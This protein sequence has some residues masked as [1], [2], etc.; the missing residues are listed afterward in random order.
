MMQ[1]LVNGVHGVAVATGLW[2]I[3]VPGAVLWGALSALLRFLP[4]F[5]PWIAAALPITLSIA[6][7]H[8]WNQ[9]LL[10]VGMF[11]VLELVSNNVLEPWLYGAS[12]GLSPFG[13]IVSAV[14]WTWLWGIPGLVIATPLTVCFVV[15]GRYVHGLRHFAVLLGDQPALPPDVRLYQRLLAQDLDEAAVVLRD[16]AARLPLDDVSDAIVLPVLRR[17]AADDQRDAFAE[18]ETD[19]VREQFGAL[20]DEIAGDADVVVDIG[21]NC[22]RVLFVPAFDGND[23]LAIRWLTRI[24]GAGVV[25]SVASPHALTGELVAQVA[26][27]DPDAVCVSA[28]T[29]RSA[30]QGRHLCKRLAAAASRAECIIATWAAPPHEREVAR[31]NANDTTALIATTKELRA[32]LSSVR[33][34][35]AGKA[36]DRDQPSSTTLRS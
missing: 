3:G 9:P 15:A 36:D 22:A 23:A 26:A 8:G 17:L 12:V 35:C 31:P 29:P 16:A 34:R 30:A 28:L 19:A 4:Y 13:V 1:C 24:C 18:A 10:T 6:A 11:V 20:L 21:P 25:A 27:E 32:L 5:G 33:A 7:F 2:L 14:F